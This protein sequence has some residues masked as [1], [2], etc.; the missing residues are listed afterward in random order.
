[1]APKPSY[2]RGN[3]TF[4]QIPHVRDNEIYVEVDLNKI[5]EGIIIDFE[6]LIEHKNAKIL[7]D[8]LPVLQAIPLQM[9]QLPSN[10]ISN[11]LKFS[12]TDMQP[13][14]WIRSNLSIEH[15]EIFLTLR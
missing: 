9:S 5:I 6:S 3:D 14:I 2:N 10:L 12:R 11:A 15:V 13:I 4:F 1:V 8:K 7:Y